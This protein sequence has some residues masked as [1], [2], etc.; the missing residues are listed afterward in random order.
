LSGGDSSKDYNYEPRKTA[1]SDYLD[2]YIRGVQNYYKEFETMYHNLTRTFNNVSFDNIKSKQQSA[3]LS[4]CSSFNEISI[5]S[6]QTPLYLSGYFAGKNYNKIYKRALIA[7]VDQIKRFDLAQDFSDII[8]VIEQM[9]SLQTATYK[10]VQ[11]LRAKYIWENKTSSEMISL[12]YDK[13]NIRAKHT[14]SDFIERT[15]SI[16]RIANLAI[17]SVDN[18]SK[19]YNF[20][21]QMRGYIGDVESRKRLIEKFYD[22]QLNAISYMDSYV[23]NNTLQVVKDMFKSLEL[24]KQS[25]MFYLNDVN[26]I[27]LAKER[28]KNVNL[29]AKKN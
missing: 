22:Q 2:L 12:D 5:K 24:A 3:I 28:N 8:S 13:L 14:E 7:L 10:N 23:V 15:D 17:Y 21:N 29:T 11:D 19:V 4:V 25:C 18:N 16:L 27:T 20:E 1:S 26:D 6:S 9:I